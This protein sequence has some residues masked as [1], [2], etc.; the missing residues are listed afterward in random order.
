[1]NDKQPS[2]P[3]N[4]LD[5]PDRTALRLPLAVFE[6][7][8]ACLRAHIRF[9]DTRPGRMVVSIA[10]TSLLIYWVA[11]PTE[12]S[13]QGSAPLSIVPLPFSIDPRTVH[14]HYG[15]GEVIL[16]LIRPEP[17]NAAA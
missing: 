7:T 10:S 2:Q 8:G 9:E 15:E 5:P 16:D 6:Q 14:A 12:V 17:V 1:M 4:H 11:D 13:L 3:H